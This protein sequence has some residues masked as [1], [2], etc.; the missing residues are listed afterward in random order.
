MGKHWGDLASVLGLAVTF[1]AARMAKRARDAALEVKKRM[2][3]LDAVEVMSAVIATMDEIK[4]LHRIKAWELALHRDSGLRKNLAIADTA[5]TDAQRGRI[6]SALS[7]FRI[8]EA[9]VDRAVASGNIERL[10]VAR[11][12]GIMSRLMDEL[13]KIMVAMKQAGA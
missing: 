1:Y 6:A 10:D 5:M 3:R 8:M 12:N 2:W 11:F 7:Q 13:P 9:E 4:G